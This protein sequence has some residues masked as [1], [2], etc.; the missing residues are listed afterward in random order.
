MKY[1]LQKILYIFC[2]SC[3]PNKSRTVRFA[4]PMMLLSVALLGAAVA[5]APKNET[6]VTLETRT[7]NIVAGQQLS[8]DVIVSAHVPINAIDFKIT[9][10][11]SQLEIIGIDAGQSVITLWTKDPYFENN[12]VYLQGGTYRKGFVGKH[13]V[14][15]INAV[16]KKTGS[17]EILIEEVRLLAGDGSGTEVKT[18]GQKNKKSLTVRVSD[19]GALVTDIRVLQVITDLDGDGEVSLQDISIF[20]EAWRTGNV[21]YDFS[22]DGK[23]TF[24][25]FGII[26]AESFLK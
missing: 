16:A 13:F 20:M 17:A 15:R 11:S 14:A 9:Y 18:S 21:Q 12:T 19:D 5:S 24:R 7:Q 26:L 3:R 2:V 25:D 6:F 4:F 10:P 8:V 22:G 23:M 1:R